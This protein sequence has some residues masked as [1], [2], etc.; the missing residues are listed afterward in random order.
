MH[1]A[2]VNARDRLGQEGC[3]H[4]HIGGHLP[5]DQLVELYQVAGPHNPGV[6]KIQL[7]LRRRHLRV[8]LLVPEAHRALRL[9]RGV[10]E[11]LQRRQRQGMEVAAARD[12]L[13]AGDL[14]VGLL[15]GQPFYHEALHL[16]GHFGRYAAQFF[17]L[18]RQ[19][20]QQGA[21]VGFVGRLIAVQHGAE[22]YDLA[23]PENVGRQPEDAAPVHAQAQVRF[24]LRGKAADGGAIE[25]QVVAGVQEI[26]L[27]VVQHVEAPLYVREADR[28]GLQALFLL[29]VVPVFLFQFGR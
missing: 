2:A 5:A 16:A 24:L 1:A 8:V 17:K 12:K 3:R 28:H 4:P 10:Y 9:G 26:V 6:R 21:E 20:H 29:Q 27:V 22:H 15:G 18:L 13:E 7:E 19:G 25:G 14:V 11:G 23:R